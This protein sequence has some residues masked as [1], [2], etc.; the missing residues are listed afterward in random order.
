MNRNWGNQSLNTALKTKL[1]NNQNYKKTKYNEKKWLTEWK[2]ISH[3]VAT[4]QLKNVVSS[5]D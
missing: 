4:W 3:S 2:A 5:I 1:G